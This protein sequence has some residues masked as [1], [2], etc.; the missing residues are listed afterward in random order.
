MGSLEQAADEGD[1][2]EE[3]DCITG[4]ALQDESDF[5]DEADGED[6]RR[7]TPKRKVS[8]YLT[9]RQHIL[10]SLSASAADG[11]LRGC[12]EQDSNFLSHSDRLFRQT[13]E[14][15]AWNVYLLVDIAEMLRDPMGLFCL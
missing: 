8:S 12:V 3:F 11:R 5:D 13:R 10:A 4:C 15:F 1:S 9:R 6:E 14:L 7:W 2:D